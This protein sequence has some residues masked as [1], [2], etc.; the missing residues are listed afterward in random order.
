MSLPDLSARAVPGAVL[1]VRVTPKAAR[2]RIVVE[3]AVI[4]VYVTTAPE[5]GKANVA[6][7]KLLAKALGLPKSRLSLIRG[8]T[9]RDKQVRIDG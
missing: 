2:N 3:D 6:V 1:T 9:G 5:A 4:R 8:E 7:L